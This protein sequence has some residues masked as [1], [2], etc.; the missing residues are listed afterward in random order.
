MCVN[1]LTPS[2]AVFANHF[3]AAPP[4]EGWPPEV[5]QDYLVPII[6]RGPDGSR[7]V[8]MASFGMIPRRAKLMAAMDQINRTWGRGTVRSGA[9][10]LTEDWR[11][12][13]DKRSPR[14]TTDWRELLTVK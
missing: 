14:Y 6:R 3:N 8:V 2:P 9:E 12:R 1:Y 11:M 10:E 7:Q 13:Q 4:A 5:F